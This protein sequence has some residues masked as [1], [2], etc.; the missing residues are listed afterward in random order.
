MVSN[1]GGAAERS[2]I[3]PSRSLYILR[4]GHSWL[5]LPRRTGVEF[6][7]RVQEESAYGYGIP[8]WKR[9]A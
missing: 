9:S 8:I 3:S 2:S 6:H 5:C 7:L 4:Q 1:S